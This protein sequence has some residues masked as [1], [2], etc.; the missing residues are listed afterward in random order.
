L[1]PLVT[2]PHS[3]GIQ[4][5]PATSQ[6]TSIQKD[7]YYFRDSKGLGDR[8][9][10]QEQRAYRNYYITTTQTFIEKLQGEVWDSAG[11]HSCLQSRQEGTII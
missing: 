5:S 9:P 7:T 6:L 10:G 2:C 1:V 8:V 11:V 3:K 4:E